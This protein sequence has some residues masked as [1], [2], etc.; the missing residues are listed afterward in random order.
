M[1]KDIL[2]GGNAGKWPYRYGDPRDRFS[3]TLGSDPYAHL[4]DP[5]YLPPRDRCEWSPEIARDR[6][7]T[8]RRTEVIFARNDVSD[9]RREAE[10]R[11]REQRRQALAAILYGV[12]IMVLVIAAAG[13]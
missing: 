7:R 4:R 6:E 10:A 5:W 1:T 8:R 11:C 9:R 2:E 13:G 12:V 3:L